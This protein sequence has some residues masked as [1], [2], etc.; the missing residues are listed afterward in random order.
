MEY[1]SCII[2]WKGT[3]PAGVTS[4]AIIA[5]IDLFPTIMHYAGCHSFNRELDGS[6]VSSFFENPSLRLRD[7]YVYVNKGKVHGIRKGDWVYLPRTGNGKF[8]EGDV[9]ELFNLK[10]DVGEAEN[11]SRKYPDKVKELHTLMQKYV[12]NI[13]E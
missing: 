4:D 9:P 3:V 2:R 11:L 12:K 7:E 5:S 13:V 10:Q 1:G 6:D 8:R